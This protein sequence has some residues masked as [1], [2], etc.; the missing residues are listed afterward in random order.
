M[1][2]AVRAILHYIRIWDL[3]S[4][5]NVDQIVANLALHCPACLAF[6]SEGVRGAAPSRR[7]R[8]LLARGRKE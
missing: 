4:A 1:S 8:P 6:V 5:V 3:R 7:A 2:I